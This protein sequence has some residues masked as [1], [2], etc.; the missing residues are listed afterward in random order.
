MSATNGL[1]KQMPI[2]HGDIVGCCFFYST[3]SQFVQRD[4]EEEFMDLPKLQF[5]EI[6][7]NLGEDQKLPKYELLVKPA[8]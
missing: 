8:Y 7:T 6:R 1:L 3:L 5:R 4:P 2:A